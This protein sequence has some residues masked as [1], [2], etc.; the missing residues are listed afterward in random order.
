MKPYP[1]YKDSGVEW[2]GEIPE[3][4]DCSL[5]KRY[6]K[7]TDGSHYSP[8]T[9]LEGRPYISVKDVTE[10]GINFKDC[11]KISEE[12]FEQLKKNGCSPRVGDVLLTKDGT[13]GRGV[14]VKEEYPKFVALSSLGLLTPSSRLGSHYLLFYLLSGLNIEQMLRTIHGSAL[15]RLTI[16]KINDLIVC[17]PP[18]DEQTAIASYLDRKTVGIDSLIARKQRLIELYEEEKTVVINR[19]VTKGLDPDV[20]MKPSGIDWLGDIPEHW[21]VKKL[22]YLVCKIGSGVTP[23]GGASTYQLSGIPL[24]RS[25]NVHFDGLRLDDVAYISE[26]THGNM[27]GSKVLAGD[28]L[29]NITGASIGRCYFVDDTLGEANVNQHVCIIRPTMGIG[30]KFLYLVLRSSVGQTQIILEQTGGGR[31]GLNFE[32]LGSFEIPIMK[33]ENEQTAIVQHI[34]TECSRLDT[35]ID[36][37]KKQIDLLKE[38]RT[39]LISEVVTGKIDVRDEVVQ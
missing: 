24:L 7:V 17:I 9:A 14:I 8:K 1:K 35:I 2:L 21:K 29:L 5:V 15:T 13:I 16:D 3:G 34:E 28:V 32:A 4:W 36:K 26:E 25:Q 38:Y 33:D 10:K 22:K 39:T 20:K 30:T 18:S 6:C 37:F 27:A 19:A 31:E 11:K 23:R 12:D